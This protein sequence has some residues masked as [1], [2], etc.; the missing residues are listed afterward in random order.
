M[1]FIKERNGKLLENLQDLI[2]RDSIKIQNYKKKRFLQEQNMVDKIDYATFDDFNCG[3]E[4]WGGDHEYFL[5]TT[6]IT[7]PNCFSGN[8]IIYELKTGREGKWDATNPQFLAYIDGE[9]RQGLDVNHREILL[10]E[11]A[12]AGEKIKLLL[13]AYTGD[14]IMDLKMD[15][16]IKILEPEIEK[17]YYDLTVPYEVARLLDTDSDEYII[18]QKAI[19]EALNRIDFREVYSETFRKSIQESEEYIQT[20]FYQKSC[21]KSK[22]NVWCVGHTHIDVA[23]M[24]TLS[25]TQDKAV[26]SFSTVLAYMKQY[27]NYIFMSSQPQLYLYVKEKAPKIFE[28]IKKRVQEGRWEVEGAMFLEAD[29][30]LTCGESLIRQIIYGKRFF[31]KEFQ[32][33]SK[34]L[35]LP[36]VFGYSAALPQ[37]MKKCGV[38]YFMTTKISW[39]ETN[40]MPY[41]TFMW[42]GLDGTRVLTHFAPT[43]D[44]NVAAKEGSSET[45]HFTTYNGMLTPSQ[46]KGAWQR[47]NPK[48]LN[49]EVLTTYGYGDGGGGPTK[50]MLENTTRLEKGIPGCPSVKTG[51]ALSFFETLEK[52]VKGKK[53]LPAWVGELYLEY[54]RGTY[55]SMARNKKY[56]RRSEFLM[57]N[58][59]NA[60]VL[61]EMM[62]GI[63]YPREAYR[64]YWEIVLRNQFHDILPGSSICEVYQESQ[65]EYAFVLE[66]VGE[67]Y[68]NTLSAL[69]EA[70][71]AP[72]GSLVAFNMIGTKIDALLETDISVG[73]NYLRNMQKLENGNGLLW[74]EAIPAKGYCV[75]D[76]KE[77]IVNPVK[78]STTSV[79]TPYLHIKINEKGHFTSIFDKTE[80]RE[81]LQ[82]GEEAN[83]LMTYEDR[84]H[85][86]DAWDINNYYTEKEWPVEDVEKIYIEE[87]GPLRYAL[88]IEYRYLSSFIRQH[89]YFY[90]NKARFDIKNEID[91]KEKQILLKDLFPVDIHTEEATYEIQFGNVKRPTHYNTSWD[92]AKFEVCAQKWI[93]IS[94]NG[95]GVSII[96]DCKFGYSVHDGKI[97]LTMLKSAIYPNEE[98][99]KE[100]HEFTYAFLLHKNGWREADTINEAYLLNNP[101][102]IKMKESET[103]EQENKFSFIHASAKNIMVETV[104]KAE[105]EDTVIVRAYE[106]FNKR[107]KVRLSFGMEVDSV[108]ETDM[109]EEKDVLCQLEDKFTVWITFMPYEIKTFKIKI[110]GNEK[111]N[112][113]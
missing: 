44:Y 95:Y 46:V 106:S 47:Y 77:I 8:K 13:I 113:V 84:P 40:M 23:W 71:H 68:Q 70:I 28:E 5:F 104:K 103:G 18:I 6:E 66:K 100:Q 83:V 69:T 33:E 31:R 62:L 57:M 88:C 55:T 37:I 105:E 52:D 102:M 9:I 35:W 85:N 65:K 53:E 45:E 87:E 110:R 56:N 96:N 82:D 60:S 54:H 50:E 109:L 78:I 17:L 94:E 67:I 11:N 51:T 73:E 39:N 92:A 29:C 111:E 81:L 41:D 97:G 108:Y 64:N 27:P 48:E 86:F 61:A 76:T 1:R 32:K 36:D 42:E 20:E 107:S 3:E 4:V 80:Q 89:L 19:T 22:E 58:A 79:E 75:I 24:W 49:Q 30:N 16:E 59:E 63:A 99:D 43:R 90:P 34:I 2:Y 101:P 38:N 25:V 93:D 21:G 10:S 72:K 74:V 12:K 91:W 112:E 26:R 14:R 15:S 98:A 7:I